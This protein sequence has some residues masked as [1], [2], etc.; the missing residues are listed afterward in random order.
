MTVSQSSIQ[1][2]LR[3]Q[4]QEQ[5]IFDEQENNQ[6]K[7]CKSKLKQK[8]TQQDVQQEM[9]NEKKGK[10]SGSGK[11]GAAVNSHESGEYAVVA[12]MALAMQ[13]NVQ[14]LGGKAQ[15]LQGQN[16]NIDSAQAQLKL[17]QADQ[18]S[19]AKKNPKDAN[20]KAQE[21]NTQIQMTDN[22]TEQIGTDMNEEMMDVKFFSGYNNTMGGI[23]NQIISLESKVHTQSPA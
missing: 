18:E 21:I 1:L 22:S 16:A 8:K 12:A 9:K 23:G 10:L 5:Q 11:S 15:D 19:L 20:L 2:Q 6:K 7:L 4:Q 3:D 17:L 14:L 13:Q